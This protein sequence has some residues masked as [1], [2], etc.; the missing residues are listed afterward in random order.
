MLIKSHTRLALSVSLIAA[1]LACV[2]PPSSAV[3]TIE[4]DGKVSAV[5]LY[6]GQALVQRRVNVPGAGGSYEVVV[7]N[8]PEQVESSSLF[9]EGSDGLAVRAVRFRQRSVGQEPREEVRKIELEIKTVQQ[10]ILLNKKMQELAEKQMKYLDGLD[11]FAGPTAKEELV[12]GTLDAEALQKVT[13]FTFQQRKLTLEQQVELSLE[14]DQLTASLEQQQRALAELTQGSRKAVREA[15]V[16]LE[17]QGEA[18]ET[19]RLNYLVAGCGWSPTYTVRAQSNKA[20][21]SLEYNALIQ[22][23]SGEDWSSV[24]LTLS[25]ASPALSS[26][27][28]GLAPFKVTLN[29]QSQ[30]GA[31]VASKDAGELQMQLENFYSLQRQNLDDNRKAATIQGNNATAWNI[32]YGANGLQNLELICDI[33]A[34][35]MAQMS[36]TGGPT[37]SYTLATPVSLDSRTDQQIVRIT[38]A[39]L[40]SSHYHIA[41]PVLSQYVYREAELKNASQFDLLEGAVQV[42]L[43]NRFVGRSELPTVSRGQTFVVGLGADPQLRARRE[44]IDRSDDVQGGNRELGF[45]YRLKI[46]NYKQE[47]T[48]VRL[49]DRLPVSAQNGQIRVTMESGEEKLSQDSVYQEVERPQGLLRWDVEV[50]ANAGDEAA[51]VEYRYLIEYDRQF[52][53][54]AANQSVDQQ[55]KE[56]EQLQRRRQLR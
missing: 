53:L 51:T 34:L 9:A 26:A 10:K 39:S 18:A 17:K 56:F 28:P 43:D 38:Q 47:P 55:K 49:L 21:V 54:A 46:E 11:A 45:L 5:T 13:E 7:S 29:A 15:V 41:T 12:S 1:T 22:Q 35:N 44:L 42:Y 40:P 24:E 25:T 23:V 31:L 4:Q 6:R 32:N 19:L 37:L 36:L 33:D 14:A 52:N 8:L 20:D 16:F 27:G 50:A 3:E 48:L 2:A 30:K